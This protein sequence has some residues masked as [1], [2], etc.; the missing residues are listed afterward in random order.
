MRADLNVK[1]I[2]HCHRPYSESA[3]PPAG[4]GVPRKR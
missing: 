3:D 1:T 2:G 4:S